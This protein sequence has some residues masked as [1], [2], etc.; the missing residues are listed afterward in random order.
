MSKRLQVLV[1]EA[2]FRQIRAFVDRHGMSVSEWVRQAVRAAQRRE[3]S[4][5]PA[6]KLEVIRAAS[7]HAFPVADIEI[8]LAEIERGY[9]PQDQE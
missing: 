5:D 3:A 4:G 6:R 9:L 8:L 1:N 7:R 2:E